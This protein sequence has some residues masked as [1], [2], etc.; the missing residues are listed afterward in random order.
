MQQLPPAYDRPVGGVWPPARG[1]VAGNP[2][3]AF[4]P[5]VGH[6]RACGPMGTHPRDVA[7]PAEGDEDHDDIPRGPPDQNE[8]VFM[9]INDLTIQARHTAQAGAHNAQAIA[10]L[11]GF[12]R[13]LGNTVN[14]G[15]A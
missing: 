12:L 5:N 9:A 2:N 13:K 7:R 4:N 6:F 11:I 1:A 8:Y 15:F 3:V 14:E 10:D